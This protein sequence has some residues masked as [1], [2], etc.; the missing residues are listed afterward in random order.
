MAEFFAQIATILGGVVGIS[1][2]FIVI[3]L[4]FVLL[5]GPYVALTW[6]RPRRT[7]GPTDPLRPVDERRY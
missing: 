3:A 6:R 4:V 5:L 7:S 2:G 1:I